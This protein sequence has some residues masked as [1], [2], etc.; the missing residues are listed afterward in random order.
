MVSGVQIIIRVEKFKKY[1]IRGQKGHQWDKVMGDDS[2]GTVE[3]RLQQG[4]ETIKE[5]KHMSQRLVDD[6]DGE[7][8]GISRLNKL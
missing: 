4:A 5:D 1:K 6:S 2:N 8:N 3:R 7:Q